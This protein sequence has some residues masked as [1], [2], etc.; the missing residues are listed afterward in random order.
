MNQTKATPHTKRW[1]RWDAGSVGLLVGLLVGWSPGRSVPWLLCP[2]AVFFIFRGCS[3]GL[4]WSVVGRSVSRLVSWSVSSLVAF[5]TGCCCFLS[6]G[7]GYSAVW[8]VYRSGRRSVGRSVGR[9]LVRSF[10]SL[11]DLFFCCC[12]CCSVVVRLVFVCCLVGLR[13]GASVCRSV[14]R[15]VIVGRQRRA[16]FWRQ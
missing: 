10:I 11:I 8:S 3:V 7:P 1:P 5:S 15:K 12:C 9:S 6:V 16:Y 2:V 4:R 14:G 13:V